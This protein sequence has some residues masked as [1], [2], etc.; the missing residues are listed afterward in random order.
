MELLKLAALCT[1]CILPVVLLRK[2]TPEQALL[3]TIAILAV[4]AARCVSLALPL[5]EELRALFDR[6]GIEPLY[7]SIL[8]RTLAAALVTRLCADL[9]K[10]GGS[11][12]LA[13]AVETAG[14]VAALAIAMPLLKAVVELLLGYF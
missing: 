11:Q 8:L 7:L 14:A 10:D 5:M 12:A 13:S 3:L 9:C 1:V 2:Q 4:A 6:A